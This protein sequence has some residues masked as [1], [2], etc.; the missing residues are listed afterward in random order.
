MATLRFI[1]AVSIGGYAMKRLNGWSV[2]VVLLSVVGCGGGGSGKPMTTAD[3]CM[4]YA[5]AICQI[6]DMQCGL[7]TASCAS[8]QMGQCMANAA[9]VTAS[10]KRTF[11]PANVSACVNAVKSA[12]GSTQTIVPSTLAS[13]DVACGYVFQGSA[14]ALQDS[15]TTQFECA[16][17]T[18]GTIICDKGFCAMQMSTAANMPCG[19]PGQVCVTD[20]YCSANSAVRIC[21][22]S[23]V[24]G[25]PCDANNPCA[26]NLR[27]AN[28]SCTTLLPSGGACTANSDCA[29]AAP[30]CDPYASPAR[31]DTGLQFASDSPSCN[32]ITAGTSCGG[33]TTGAG[34]A[35]GAGGSVGTGGSGGGT[36]GLGGGLGG[37]GGGLGGMGGGGAGGGVSGLGGLGGVSGLGGLGGTV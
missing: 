18:N 30:Y 22:A 13:I 36:G 29:P 8:Y 2:A 17:A 20:Y 35:G 16:G 1:L 9:S 4:Q 31:C 34:G 32:C 11:T 28:G 14:V 6:A 10:G 21:T 5:D 15:C 25:N 26:H 27:C 19:N 24:S 33:G 3:F 12:Y 7:S 23:G 37:V